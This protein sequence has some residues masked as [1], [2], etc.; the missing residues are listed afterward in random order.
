[1]G[2]SNNVV[3]LLLAMVSGVFI[4]ASF[5]LKKKGLRRAGK[6]GTRAGS[7][8]RTIFFSW[9][10]LDRHL[11]SCFL[12]SPA[13]FFIRLSFGSFDFDVNMCWKWLFFDRVNYSL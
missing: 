12:F 7:L 4:G 6:S 13:Y 5:I 10:L 2:V 3:G 11:D 8:S 1:M 9:Y